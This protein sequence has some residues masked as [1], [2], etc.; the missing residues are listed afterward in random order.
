MSKASYTVSTQ[1]PAD[2]AK[3]G[4]MITHRDGSTGWI[5]GSDGDALFF[6]EKAQASK[7]LKELQGDDRYSWNCEAE[8]AAFTG[9][10]K[11]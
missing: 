6:H 8:V 1:N 11:G 10:G 7:K 9:W 5:V 4:I 2:K 3:Y